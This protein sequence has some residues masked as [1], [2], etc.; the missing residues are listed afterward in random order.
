MSAKMK[1]A[2]QKMASMTNQTFK[3]ILKLMQKQQF[4]TLG[5]SSRLTS[6][7]VVTVSISIEPPITKFRTKLAAKFQFYVVEPMFAHEYRRRFQRFEI[8]L[9]EK[10]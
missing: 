3:P 10:L 6:S 5:Y 2:N 8:T 4:S 1:S 9:S 7:T